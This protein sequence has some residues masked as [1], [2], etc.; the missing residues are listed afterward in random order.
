M[1]QYES[2]I[3][4][5]YAAAARP[6]LWTGA[7]REF[8]RA[9]GA[10]DALVQ[11]YSWQDGRVMPAFLLAGEIGPA[12]IAQHAELMAEIGDPRA[13][14]GL[15][16]P[17]GKTYQDTD[18]LT[19]SEMQNSRYYNEL[20]RPLDLWHMCAASAFLIHDG[21]T[22]FGIGFSVQTAPSQ[23]PLRDRNMETWNQIAPHM[24]RAIR[25]SYRLST[26]T[27][28]GIAA[29]QENH[30]RFVLDRRGRVLNWNAAAEDLLTSALVKLDSDKRLHLQNPHL[31]FRIKTSLA[32]EIFGTRRSPMTGHVV[33]E[34]VRW[35]YCLTPVPRIDRRNEH[36][37]VGRAAIELCLYQEPISLISHVI[38]PA[39][40]RLV[41]R[42]S[43]GLPL[44]AIAAEFAVSYETIRSQCKSAM[45]K[46]GVKSQSALV[47]AWLQGPPR[48]S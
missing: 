17:I 15:S 44:K 41:E 42:L 43:A 18:F 30:A 12:E 48:K 28:V 34:G 10:R 25:L 47:A 1:D 35:I 14:A 5:L 4:D 40:R 26:L 20:L 21:G 8:A 3:E 7:L 16:T 19:P 46:L 22:T 36:P 45:H 38:T 2:L 9:T 37:S 27:R 11:A 31:D 39:E 23:G 13:E 24:I 32:E 6:E 29:P 33:D